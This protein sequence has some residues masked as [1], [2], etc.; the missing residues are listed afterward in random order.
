MSEFNIIPVPQSEK[1]AGRY[2]AGLLGDLLGPLTGK[3]LYKVDSGL[4]K[5]KS[6]GI[7][8]L[9]GNR[10][11]VTTIT[12]KTDLLAITGNPVIGSIQFLKGKYKNFATNG[13]VYL[14]EID[15]DYT[16]PYATICTYER[17]KVDA[18]TNLRGQQ[19]SVK[20]LFGFTDYKI[21][22]RGFIIRDGHDA[23]ASEDNYDQAIFPNFS[24]ARMRNF[25]DMPDS[26]Q[27]A[28]ALFSLLRI[29][30]L[31]IKSIGFQEVEGKPN[32]LAYNISALSD[33]Q[34]EINIKP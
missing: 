13:S 11:R 18:L 33:N 34:I 29:R 32:V 22:M 7:D 25:C 21:Q 19:G 24:A 5:F 9:L 23:E 14:D 10:Y 6:D 8:K 30:R 28:G 3:I 26:I 1:A 2:A 17:E 15:R 16:L 4:D 12:P 27:V 20:E 31:Y